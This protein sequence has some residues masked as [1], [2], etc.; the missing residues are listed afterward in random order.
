VFFDYTFMQG[1]P[2]YLASAPHGMFNAISTLVF[3]V[4][5]LAVMFLVLCFDLWPLTLAPSVMQQP[6]LGLV[7][8]IVCAAGAWAVMQL[9]VGARGADP[10][11]VLTQITAPFIFGSIL[12]LNMFQNSL[13]A[14]FAQPVKG[15]LN[16]ATAAVL[17]VALYSVYAL[18][19]PRVTGQL[20]GGPPGF[21][22]EVWIANALLS[23]T[24]PFLIFL[25]AYFAYWP[26]AK[27]T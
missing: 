22:Y 21:D 27:R 8:T 1:A 10:M 16:A 2:V 6:A 20:V 26:L 17:G 15:L 23:V 9:A 18:L 5:A 12:V 25:A 11:S 24:F 4:T 19:M 3:Y 7:W 13:Y 14:K